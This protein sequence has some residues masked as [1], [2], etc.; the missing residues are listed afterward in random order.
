MITFFRQPQRATLYVVESQEA[1]DPTSLDRLIWLF[2][3]AE[4]LAEHE[5][6]GHFVGTRRELVTPWSTNAVEIVRN[7]NIPGVKRIEE[8]TEVATAD[9]AYDPMLQHRYEGLDQSVFVTDFSA[10][11]IASVTDIRAYNEAEGLALSEE[12]IVYLEELAGRLGRPLTDSEL[13]GFSQVNSEHCRHKIFGGTFVLDG[14]EQERSLFSMIKDTSAANPNHLVSA[15]KDNVAFIDGPQALEQFAPASGD[16]PDYFVCKSIDSVLSLKAETHNFPTTVEPFNGAATGTG[17]EIRDRMAGGRASVPLAGTAVYMTSYPRSEAG[18]SWEQHTEARPWLYQTP[19]QILTK[20]SNGASDFGNKFGQPLICGS[21]LTFEQDTPQARYGFDKVIMLAG[22]VGYARRSDAQ[23]GTPK[24]GE[25]VVLLGGD[26]YR[27]GMGGGAVSSVNTGQ[28]AGAIELNAV[29][30]SNPEMQKRVQNVIRTLSEG[31][32]NPIISIHDHGAGGHLNCLSELVETTGGHFDLTRFPVGDE[33]LSDK[34]IIGNESQERMGLLVEKEALERIARIAERERAPMYVVGETTD[35][36]HLTFEN[37]R[38]E[39]PIDLALS[40]MFGSAPKTYMRDSRQQAVQ[41]ALRYEPS[42][43]EQYLDAVLQQESVAC[44]DW[45]TNKVDRSVTGRVARQQCQ[46][47]L[48]LPLSDCGAMAVDF[49]GRAGMATSI[50]HAPAAAL[51]DPVAGSQLAIAEALTNIVF[52]PLTYGLEG[53][54]LSANWMWPCRNPGEDARLYDAVEAASDLAISLGINIPTGKDSLSMTQ[55]Y[56]DGSKV[57]SPGTVIISAMAEVSDVKEILSPVLR[58]DPKYPVYHIDFSFAPLALGGS[59]LAQALGELGDET[60]YIAEPE[61]FREAFAAVQEALRRGILVSG[62]DISGGGLITALLELCFSHTEGGLS[63]DLSAFPESDWV[64]LL[65]AEN[66]GVLVQTSDPEQLE[67]LLRDASLGF[68]RLATPV[69]GSRTLT[70]H[71]GGRTLELDIDQKRELW[72]RSS[73]LMDQHQSG[74]ELARQRFEHYKEQPL[75]F[76]FPEGF[77]GKLASLGLDPDRSAK[78]PVRAAILRDKGTN[79]ERE[80]AYA[81]WLAG[82]DVKDVHLTD[83]ISGRETLE[84]VQLIVFCGGFSNSDV[85]GSAKGWAAG[86]LFNERAKATL[87]RFY[88]R[89]DT[90]SLGICNGCQLMA[91]LELLYPEHELK[92]KM[93]HNDSHKFESAFVSLTIPENHS[94]MLGNL[95]GSE[96]GVWLAH[97]EGKF[98]LPYS[99]DRYHVIARY[100]YEGYPANP[101]GSPEGIAGLC[102]ADGRH[103]ALMPHPERAIFPWQCGYYPEGERAAHEVTPWMQAFRNAY[104]WCLE[105]QAKA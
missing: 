38:G 52:A 24:P 96:L 72:Y 86:I 97:G 27:I 9:A 91:E 7:M 75:R 66:P 49:R 78:A 85:L 4:P 73:Y 47:L 92:H 8:F 59:A 20:A 67:A 5:L 74:E 29:Q 36:M 22:G 33:T 21:V 84:E 16:K 35:D 56:P 45:L 98:D 2:A 87:D 100:A 12:E 48:Q 105:H 1:L 32:D 54:S 18:R 13:F 51:V 53:V 89:P 83:L 64:K 103:L 60:P 14:E 93:A 37:A 44:K 46:G 62:H 11:P 42:Q 6:K 41:P 15:Y 65:F 68:V 101:N 30:R 17:G 80:M 40:D 19:Q 77:D 76:R 58:L 61:Y 81:L 55:K 34:E 71:Q 23:K 70:L 43:L 25:Q 63:V 99:S 3:G 102:S 104:D 57:L 94:V 82:F 10:A 69:L 26:N 79:G 31:E 39:R 28:Y 50:G 90:L 88:A 95:A